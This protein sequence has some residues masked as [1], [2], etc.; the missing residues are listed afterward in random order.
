MTFRGDSFLAYDNCFHRQDLSFRPNNVTFSGNWTNSE[1]CLQ[2][3]LYP[4]ARCASGGSRNI[5]IAFAQVPIQTRRR[6]KCIAFL[7]TDMNVSTLR[8]IEWATP[9][10]P[11]DYRYYEIFVVEGPSVEH[12][13]IVI[14]LEQDIKESWLRLVFDN[15]RQEFY[16]GS[17]FVGDALVSNDLADPRWS[18]RY[19]DTANIEYSTARQTFPSEDGRIYRTADVSVANMDSVTAF[20]A[21]MV[22]SEA[23]QTDIDLNNMSLTGNF[24]YYRSTG[25]TG[26]LI[27]TYNTPADRYLV[28]I[29][30]NARSDT[31]GGMNNVVLYPYPTGPDAYHASRMSFLWETPNAL[32]D[33]RVDY[34]VG[35]GSEVYLRIDGVREVPVQATQ[36]A[37]LARVFDL[38]GSS[39]P[40][41][42]I[43]RYSST[44]W[45]SHL[46]IYGRLSRQ[47]AI[48]HTGGGY[49]SANF[50]VE[51]YL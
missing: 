34:S 21:H 15:T 33:M 9:I 5:E 40:V 17:L 27:A 37:S 41:I 7:N 36:E 44:Q 6:L 25:T 28:D 39:R 51:E 49:Y 14:Y 32:S 35:S 3:Q 48:Q 4:V 29:S 47:G 16:I 30:A 24:N 1:N 20:A 13:H 38:C 46:C 26:R 42:Y 12:R 31:E 22:G 10:S 50:T 43:G 45:L 2:T 23:K 19:S 8:K 11:A 18:Q